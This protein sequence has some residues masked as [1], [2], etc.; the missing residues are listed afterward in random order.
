QQFLFVNL[1]SGANAF[2]WDFGDGSGDTVQSPAKSYADTGTYMVKLIVTDTAGCKDSIRKRILLKE[3]PVA[4]I[5]VLANNLCPFDTA[6]LEAG[7]PGLG[8]HFQWLKNGIANPADT[9]TQL[10]L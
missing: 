6:L 7:N 8:D 2:N 10:K 4:G 9:L 1:S 5:N 3:S